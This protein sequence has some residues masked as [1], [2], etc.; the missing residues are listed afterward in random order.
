MKIYGLED[1]SDIASAA[2]RILRETFIKN[3]RTNTVLYV[4]HDAIW[5]KAPDSAPVLI[6]HLSG[7]NPDTA[8]KI[9]IGGTYKIG[10]YSLNELSLGQT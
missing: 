9:A 3:A 8:P 5:S 6:K 10:G 1:E 4:E 7:R 2:A